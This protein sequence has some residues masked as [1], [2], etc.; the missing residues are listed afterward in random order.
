[1]RRK[2]V[3]QGILDMIIASLSFGAMTG[4]VKYA[5]KTLPP[6]E[7]VFWRSLFGSFLMAVLVIK[8]KESFFGK[9]L[10]LLL[11]RGIFGFI[12]LAMNFY[13][14]SKLNVGVAVILNYTSPIFVALISVLLL[15]EKISKVLWTLT[16]LCFTGLYLLVGPQFSFKS[17]PIMIGLL[18][19]VMAALA[20][21]TIRIASEEESSSVIIFYFTM[22]STLGSLPLLYFG[23]KIPNAQEWLSIGGIVIGSFFGQVFLT[24]SIREA[25]PSIVCPFSYL[26][27]VFSFILGVLIWRDRFSVGS[28]VGAAFV[29]TSG[30]VIYLIEV[31]PEPITD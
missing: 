16:V 31:R 14:I 4:F 18:S 30:V 26:T 6:F 7:I 2:A 22:V 25:P 17:F 10:K 29:I 1:M 9:K 5:S 27:P 13:A 12:A 15:K 19:G 21:I 3:S 28:L 20:Y 8:E 11:M 23:F 24:K